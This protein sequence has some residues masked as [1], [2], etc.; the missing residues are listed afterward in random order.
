MV[1]DPPCFKVLVYF[2]WQ[3]MTV[4]A[5]HGTTGKIQREVEER[6]LLRRDG[7]PFR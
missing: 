4:A 5:L 3:A 1:L 7:I 2:S 6:K